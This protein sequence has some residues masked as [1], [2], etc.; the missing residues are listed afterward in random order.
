MVFC[1]RKPW[2]PAQV[3]DNFGLSATFTPPGPLFLLLTLRDAIASLAR[4][5]IQIVP[6]VFLPAMQA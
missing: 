2:G 5:G 6:V 3:T 4:V 1:R